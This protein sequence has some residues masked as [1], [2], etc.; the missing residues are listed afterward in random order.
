VLAS[1]RIRP[2]RSASRAL[3]VRMRSSPSASASFDT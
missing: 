2:P 1:G 3:T